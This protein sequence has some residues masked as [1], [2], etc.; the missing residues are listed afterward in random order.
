[1]RACVCDI[2]TSNLKCLIPALYFIIFSLSVQRLMTI[3]YETLHE[4]TRSSS[5]CA[6]R[7]FYAVNNVFESFLCIVPTFHKNGLETLPQLSG[8]V[9]F[10][11]L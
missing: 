2:W 5:Q 6:V 7:L 3:V 10:K 4:A 8:T 9:L 11:H 1:M